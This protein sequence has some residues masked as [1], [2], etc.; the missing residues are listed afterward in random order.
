M[1]NPHT[2]DRPDERPAPHAAQQVLVSPKQ[3]PLCCP[4][5]ESSQWNGHPR[6]FLPIGDHDGA[7]ITCPYCGT[8]YI[9]TL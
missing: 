3:L 6:I 7:R 5:P 9:L 8:R 2:A 4:L 1:P